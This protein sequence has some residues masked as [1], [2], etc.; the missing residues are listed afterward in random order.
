MAGGD[1]SSLRR[2]TAKSL[3]TAAGTVGPQGSWNSCSSTRKAKKE[4]S[5]SS[6]GRVLRPRRPTGRKAKEDAASA[7]AAEAET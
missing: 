3:E 7:T 1:G 4:A 6:G 2:C 5:A